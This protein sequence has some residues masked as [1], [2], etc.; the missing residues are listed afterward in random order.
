MGRT[1]TP[2]ELAEALSFF[3]PGSTKSVTRLLKRAAEKQ[4][5]EAR[6]GTRAKS[7]AGTKVG[8]AIGNAIAKQLTKAMRQRGATKREKQSVKQKAPD[9]GGR[10][11]HF[12]H[13]TVNKEAATGSTGSAA[14][15]TTKAS[16]HMRYIEREIAVERTF[17]QD[18]E[19]EARQPM[20]GARL[21]EA[22]GMDGPR[23]QE[24]GMGSPGAA[25]GYIENPV[26][27]A[28]GENVIFSF[29]T[30]GD[31]FEDR[32]KFWQELEEHEVH[33]GARVQNRLIVELPHEATPQA[34]FEIVKEFCGEMERR[35]LP[36]WAALHA[37]GKD[38]DSRNFHAH[39]VFSERPATR[40]VDEED[41][42][43]K[44]DFAVTRTKVKASR[45]VVTQHPYRQNRHPDF[46]RKDVIGSLRKSF[47]ETT[48]RV[49]A[50]APATGRDGKPVVYDARSYKDM[51]LDT[52]PM[53]SVDR[54]VADK[55]RSGKLTV[56][57]GDFTKKMIRAE[58][59][60]ALAR[61][62]RDMMELVRLDQALEALAKEPGKARKHNGRLPKDMRVSPLAQM[63]GKAVRAAATKVLDAKRG[64]LSDDL[65][66]R[67]T[68]ASLE[69]VI[70]ATD[71]SV[72]ESS[73]ANTR[74]P[75]RRAELPSAEA[76]RLLNAAAREE[77][78]ILT[79]ES[80]VRRQR[81]RYRVGLALNGWRDVVGAKLPQTEPLMARTIAENEGPGEAR[82]KGRMGA[83][84]IRVGAKP[85][86]RMGVEEFNARV[87]AASAA[88]SAFFATIAELPYEDR[89]S[90]VD[91]LHPTAMRKARETELREAAERDG[92]KRKGMRRRCFAPGVDRRPRGRRP[93]RR[94]LRREK[95][96]RW[97]WTPPSRERPRRSTPREC[98]WARWA[99]RT[100]RRGV[101]G[102]DGR[103]SARRSWRGSAGTGGRGR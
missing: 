96:L 40:M 16:A 92:K 78:A 17:G 18:R 93:S 60:E 68:R 101:R 5:K 89:L 43:E 76:A 26:K 41:G 57:D 29:G 31:R 22:T 45:N 19:A 23:G 51:G 98:P 83:E 35:G 37:P 50:R 32:V 64:A 21:R 66:E 8:K 42:V 70:Q 10:P 91:S 77:L 85:N 49:L 63:T 11:F 55:M 97:G 71:V 67:S 79:E 36:Y 3:P 7:N 13:T 54:I 73:T 39:I 90:I 14:K 56:L 84:A 94:C 74:D 102:S 48:N 81:T 86:A 61:R 4:A 88:T 69:R 87:V 95:T 59:Q 9:T 33:P 24:P 72:V 15:G 99:R 100:R 30:I 38:N 53:R 75:V 44:W 65:M 62:D 2:E 52:V 58:L 34:R 82:A 28:N 80:K 20:G 47:A 25:Q 6:K 12:A 103:G 46:R 27:L 1:K